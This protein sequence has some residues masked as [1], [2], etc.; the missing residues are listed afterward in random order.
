[1]G[2]QNVELQDCKL[3]FQEKR[4]KKFIWESLRTA[5]LDYNHSKP[6]ASPQEK[7]GGNSYRGEKEVRRL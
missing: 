1:M 2:H 7:V 5:I 6:W 3:L 4:K